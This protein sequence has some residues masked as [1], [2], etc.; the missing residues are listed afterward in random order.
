MRSIRSA[1]ALA[2]AG[3][4]VAAT[5]AVA[6]DSAPP[7]V[8]I[9]QYDYDV[10]AGVPVD[11]LGATGTASDDF[12]GVTSVRVTYCGNGGI[13]AGGGWSCGSGIGG[14]SKVYV[15]DATLSCDAARRS[16]TWAAAAPLQPDHYLVFA[17]ATDGVGRTADAGPVFVVVV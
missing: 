8:T 14:L 13:S 1:A 10:L 15:V 12:A 2:V 17:K 16:C 9:D 7:Q 6:A 11:A 3:V 5:G 4:A